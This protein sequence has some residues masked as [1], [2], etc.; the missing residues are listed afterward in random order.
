MWAAV[1]FDKDRG[2]YQRVLRHMDGELI[3]KVSSAQ[4]GPE[5][6]QGRLVWAG[7]TGL[8]R[9]VM[10]VVVLCL[11]EVFTTNYRRK[12]FS[13]RILFYTL[14]GI[15]SAIHDQEK[16]G[17]GRD[18]LFATSPEYRESCSSGKYPPG[19]T[20]MQLLQAVQTTMNNEINA[21]PRDFK[22]RIIFMSENNDIGLDPEEQ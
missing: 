6:P 22:G 14:A 13:S 21:H 12:C 10:E 19:H 1:H 15:F 3:Q 20:T 4:L 5:S 17:S 11:I 2:Q 9:R 16:F 18:F 7:P 8:A